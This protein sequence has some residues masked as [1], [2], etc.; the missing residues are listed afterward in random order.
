MQVKG[1]TIRDY[2]IKSIVEIKQRNRRPI[3]DFIIDK[4]IDDGI[5]PNIVIDELYKMKN[6]KYIYFEGER[7][8]N[9][10]VEIILLKES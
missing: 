1:E 5:S 6:D 3:A 2:I 10:T 4:A 7:I 9:G 8:Q